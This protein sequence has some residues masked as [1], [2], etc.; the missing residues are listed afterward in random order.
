MITLHIRPLGVQVT[1]DPTETTV[2]QLKLRLCSS[3]YPLEEMRL[4]LAGRILNDNEA[5]L[6]FYSTGEFFNKF[7]KE[8]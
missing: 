6:S 2:L 3:E 1:V 5:L 8:K 7:K 4:I